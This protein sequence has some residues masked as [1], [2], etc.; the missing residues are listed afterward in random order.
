M[1][2]WAWANDATSQTTRQLARSW[3]AEAQDRLGRWCE[4]KSISGCSGPVD[5][6][7]SY[8]EIRKTQQNCIAIQPDR[9][10]RGIARRRT[11]KRRQISFLR[12]FGK[13]SSIRAR[14]C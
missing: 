4:G 7:L 6:L 8:Q 3:Y 13:K 14:V 11:V 9:S 2:S 12:R 5:K 10:A 1:R